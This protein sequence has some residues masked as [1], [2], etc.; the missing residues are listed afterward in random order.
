MTNP[1]RDGLPELPPKMRGLPIDERGY[2][3]PFFVAIIDGKP[4]HR[5]ADPRAQKACVEHNRC[6]ICGGPLGRFRAF[7]IGPMCMVTETS[8]EPPSHL[9]CAEYAVKACPFL[10]RPKAK[11]REAGMP[12]NLQAPAG[13]FIQRNPTAA[14]IWVTVTGGPFR[15]QLGKPGVLFDIGTPHAVQWYFEGGP[16]TRAQVEASIDSGR[17]ELEKQCGTKAEYAHLH[18]RLDEVRVLLDGMFAKGAAK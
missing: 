4:D 10:A 1:L 15:A 17:V 3:V 12:E 9:E 6:W 7:V 18:K 8:G 11:R 2:P 14:G 5:V 16:A 13:V